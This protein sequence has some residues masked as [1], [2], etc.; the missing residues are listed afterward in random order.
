M[1]RVED[2][3]V[4][5]QLIDYTKTRAQ[6]AYMGEVLFP[7]RKTEALEIDI[8]KGANNLPVSAKIHAFDTEAEIGS[9]EGA[10]RELQDL[11][12]I[13]RKIKLSEKTIIALESPRNN[14]EEAEMVRNIFKDVDNLVA[15]IRTR[16][17]CMRMEATTTGKIV[18]NENG[19]KATIDYGMP[20]NHKATKDWL[21]NSDA[22]ILEDMDAMVNT[23]VDN[24]GFTPARVI[25]S[26]KILNR[27]LRD[28]RIRAA[29]Y[30]VNS[31]K[32]LTVAMLNAFLA[33]QQ[34]PVIAIYDKKYREQDAKGKYITKRFFPEDCFV[35]LPDGKLG[36]TFYGVT[37]EELKLRKNPG[38]DVEEIGN[39]IVCR[40]TTED[41]VAE[42]IKAVATSLPSFPYADQVF[43]ATIA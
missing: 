16:V 7:E 31:E 26:K 37:A 9:R 1:A 10:E 18:V 5:R 38:V 40:H 24:T 35:M 3:L 6:E 17:E 13:K 2:L 41:P 14:Q 42:W 8:V 11:A 4:P 25:T 22:K 20:A 28:E 19:V 29:I 39:I 21:T 34:L 43:S 36:D 30:G 23:I 12:L 15:S 27:I 32:M 33:E